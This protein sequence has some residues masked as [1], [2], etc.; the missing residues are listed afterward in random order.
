MAEGTS[1]QQVDHRAQALAAT[2]YNVGANLVDEHHLGTQPG[3]D[4]GIDPLHVGGDELVNRV[5][6]HQDRVAA[7][8][9]VH[10]R[11]RNAPC[12]ENR[13]K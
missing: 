1:G 7:A 12:Q 11:G 6:I 5:D 3:L 9:A 2:I 8:K 4:T 10:A 13:L